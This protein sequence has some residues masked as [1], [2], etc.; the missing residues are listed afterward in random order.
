MLLVGLLQVSAGRNPPSLR[1]K[2]GRKGGEREKEGCE[3]GGR[4]KRRER[5][6]KRKKGGRYGGRETE[7][8]RRKRNLIETNTQ[9][10]GWLSGRAHRRPWVQSLGPKITTKQISE[11]LMIQK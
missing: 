3:E 5:K 10:W 1:R 2:D 6:G 7:K 11:S 9:V 4:R 8:I